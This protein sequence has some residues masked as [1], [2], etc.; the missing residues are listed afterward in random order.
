[1]GRLDG[2]VCIVTGAGAGIGKE[3]T[4]LFAREGGK[5]VCA[6]RREANGIPVAQEIKAS[7]GD[8][9]FVL[10][11][12]SS[13]ESVMWLFQQ[14]MMKYGRL[15]VLVNNAGVNFVKPF[16][17]ISI[18]DWDRVINT[19][20]RGTFLCIQQAI[21]EMLKAGG[22]SIINIT[23]V[24]TLACME[25]AAPYDAAKWGAVGLSKS[26]SVEFAS[27]GVRVN[28]L[29]PGLIATQIWDD[30]LDAAEDKAACLN[31]WKANIP[32]ARV[33][34]VGDVAQA[35]LFLASDESKYIC[36]ANIVVDG[37]M[38]SQLVSRPD[39][40]SRAIDGNAR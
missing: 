34:S 38:T 9:I 20:L 37:G 1:M 21:P 39:Y 8:A 30:I 31:Y 19:D 15:D 29:S 4:Q 6:S 11:D 2:K 27:R 25:G 22:G 7:G 24:H 28:A 3:I 26:L 17:D 5:V 12:V 14:T 36:G 32:A 13:P 16:L 33:G 35:A 10:C 18:E 40:I 23:S